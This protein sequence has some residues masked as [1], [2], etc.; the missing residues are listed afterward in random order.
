MPALSTYLANKLNDCSNGV[1]PFTLPTVFIALIKA[2][3]GV[4]PR[5]T[6]VT[7]GQTTVPATMNGHMYRCTTAGTTGAGEPTWPTGSGAT[8]ADGS[9]VWT[10]MTP[11]FQAN[12]N[13]TEAD[14]TGYARAALAGDMGSSS[15]GAAANSA[16]VT[17]P[18]ATGGNN[19]IAAWASFDAATVGNLLKFAVVNA[20]LAVSNGIT[21]QFP[22]GD[23]TTSQS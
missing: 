16:V 17:F 11:D 6:V 12:A 23:L 7:S 22:V 13:L 1:A 19:V 14:Y 9:V 4:S 2:S 15:G 10:E 18:Q 20:T 5:S 8:V 21:P 3:A